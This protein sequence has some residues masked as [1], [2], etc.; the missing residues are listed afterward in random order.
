MRVGIDARELC[1]KPTGV[2]R[3]LAGLLAAWAHSAHAGRH[4]FVL[5][6]PDARGASVPQRAV[7]RVVPGSGGTVWEQ[8]ALARAA[9]RERLDVFFAPGYTAPLRLAMPSVV[10][11]HDLSFN[12]HPEWF[13]LREGIRRRLLTKWAGAR[14][15]VIL[16][17]SETA[18]QEILDTFG[19]PADRVRCVYP[20]ISTLSHDAAAPQAREPLV[21]FAGSIF[22]RRHLPDLIEAFSRVHRSHPDARLEIVGDNRTYPH[23]RLESIAAAEGMQDA[24]GI[25]SYVSD[26]ALA[27]LYRR[28]RAFAFLSDYE[29]FGHPPLEALA[30]GV[31]GVLLDTPVSRETCQD[32]ALYV[33]CRVTAIAGALE[34]LLFDAA[35]RER[36]LGAAPAV[37]ARY[38]WN[39][40]A[41]QTLDVL[42]QAAA[43]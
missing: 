28:A 30:C 16:A 19:L 10:L 11:V 20:G 41:E 34:S 2:G 5:F 1:G 43:T 12:A 29:G 31:P 21:L 8:T 17:V 26:A 38:S 23:Q 3:H 40:A 9:N 33:K 32:A 42:E 39:R 37:L 7:V 6:V 36:I 25:R 24:I 27:D 13:R 35:A 14:A 15:T 4:E 18:R 22:N